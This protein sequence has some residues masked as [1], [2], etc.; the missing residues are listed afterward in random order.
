[1][2]PCPSYYP[3]AGD[4]NPNTN[5]FA[6]SYAEMAPLLQSAVQRIGKPVG[7][8]YTQAEDFSPFTLGEQSNLASQATLIGAYD[9]ATGHNIPT[10]FWS[11]MRSQPTDW[12]FAFGHPI[13][14]PIWVET[15]IAGVR[16]WVLVQLFERR[17]L[18]YTPSNTSAWQV[19]M[20]NVGQHAYAWR[21]GV[22]PEN[23]PW[24][25]P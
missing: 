18:T 10:I 15:Q 11:Y 1:T 8:T 21:Y 17:T 6:P 2:Q 23:P 7:T 3:V 4:A 20:G 25:K 5:G 9:E 19:E 13:S 22:D 12:L 14:E 16:Q 24:A